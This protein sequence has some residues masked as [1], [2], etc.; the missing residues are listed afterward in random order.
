MFPSEKARSGLRQQNEKARRRAIGCLMTAAAS[1]PLRQMADTFPP[2]LRRHTALVVMLVLAGAAV[3]L[4][5][6]SRQSSALSR[7]AVLA[8]D[9]GASYKTVE[10]AMAA[11][12]AAKRAAKAA[13]RK[14]EQLAV[15]RVDRLVLFLM[16]AADGEIKGKLVP[17]LPSVMPVFERLTD[18]FTVGSSIVS[19]TADAEPQWNQTC[20]RTCRCARKLTFAML[21]GRTVRRREMMK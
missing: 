10:E 8:E 18:S 5:A 7:P 11:A 16:Q 19:P 13:R 21:V 14:L 20:R 1:Q 12:V 9:L 17:L 2:P 3:V 6:C 4:V 15:E